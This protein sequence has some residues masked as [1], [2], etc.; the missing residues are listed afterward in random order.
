M[1]QNPVVEPE[2]NAEGESTGCYFVTIGEGRRLAQML[3]VKRKQIKKTE[4]IRCV[5]DIEN[6]ATEISLDENVTCEAIHPADQFERFRELAENRGW[7]AEEIA[8]R[9]GVTAHVVRQ[10]L[11]L[12][13]VRKGVSRQSLGSMGSLS[14]AS[15][16]KTHS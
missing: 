14:S 13:A 7:G 9:F 8:A 3:R 2:T 12:G 10:R 16:A 6:D 15:T 4:A 11:R 1:L 5:L